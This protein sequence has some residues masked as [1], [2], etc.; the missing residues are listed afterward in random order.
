MKKKI[1][2]L[3]A[4]AGVLTLSA[5]ANDTILD[6]ENGVVADAD[7]ITV[8]N[9]IDGHPNIARL[10]A[11]GVA[12]ATTMREYGDAVTRVPEWDDYCQGR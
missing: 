3:L 6:N 11:D 10:C 1:A 5:C 2:A 7:E 12:F 8:F 9:N 4:V